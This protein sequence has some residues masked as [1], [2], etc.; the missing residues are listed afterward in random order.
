MRPRASC[1]SATSTGAASPSS[2]TARPRRSS[3]TDRAEGVRLAD[4]RD[5]ARRSGGARHRHP[6]QHRPGARRRSG[7]QSR[8]HGRSTTCA[9]AIRTSSRSA[10]ASSIAARC[11]AWWRRC[12]TG[13]GLRRAAAG[14][15]AAVFAA[16]RAVDQPEDHRRRC[17]LG[18]RADGG[19]RGRRRDHAARRRAAASTRRS[20]CAT[21]S[22]SAPCST[23]MSPT[24]PGI[25][26]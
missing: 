6:S 17:V 9:P 1:C 26:S 10:N 2:P 12:G 4:G 23:A 7:R 15:E 18:R 21:A 20:C 16:A 24:A 19:G 13:E 8:H 25:C 3:A 22:W 5:D 11:S 14:D